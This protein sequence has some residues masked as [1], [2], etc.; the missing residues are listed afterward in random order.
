MQIICNFAEKIALWED[1]IS[2]YDKFA[3]HN[4]RIRRIVRDFKAILNRMEEYFFHIQEKYN[5]YATPKIKVLLSQ[6]SRKELNESKD[7]LKRKI[8]IEF[9]VIHLLNSNYLNCFNT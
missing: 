3:E 6:K 8:N 1:H 5:Y 4:V 9:I 2:N 7:S